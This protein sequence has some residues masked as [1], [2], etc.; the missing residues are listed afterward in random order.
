MKSLFKTF[1][2]AAGVAMSAEILPAQCIGL[3]GEWCARLDTAGTYTVR[4]P[5]TLDMTKA[6]IP[7]PLEP[8]MT[9]PQLLR[10]TRKTSYIGPCTYS[11]TVDIPRK[12]AGKPLRLTM[13]RVLWKS[14]VKVD[15]HEINGEN[16]SLNSPH[17][18]VLPPL[19][20]GPH[21]VEITV[22]NRQQ[23]D[24]SFSKLCHSYTDDTQTIWN[25]V[26]GR[27]TLCAIRQMEIGKPRI[28][29]DVRNGSVEVVLPVANRSGRERKSGVKLT[30]TDKSTGKVVARKNVRYAA[31][32]G[33]SELKEVLKIENPKL[34][35][36]FSPALYCLKAE[37]GE[38]KQTANFG[39]REVRSEGKSL[40]VNGKKVFLRG[41]LDCCVFPLTGVPPTDKA[42]WLKEMM[43]LKDWGFNHIRFHSWCPPEAAFQI[44]D[45][46]GLYVQA[47][48]PVW[49]LNIGKD[50]AVTEFLRDEFRN[51][52]ENYGNHPSWIMST[53][54]N[55]LQ[56]DFTVLNGLVRHMRETDPRHL[57]AATSFTFEKG[58]GGHAEP[59]DQFLIT[60]WTDDG[61][62]RGQGV[63]DSE[64]PSFDRN[65][66][67]SMGCVSVP[68]VSH[69]IGQYAVYP[70]L[71]EIDKYT[72]VL[73][74]LNFKAIRN[75][76]QA[77]GLSDKAGEYLKRTGAFARILYKEEIERALKTSG[78]SGYQLLGI[79]DFPGQG[80][81]LVGLLNVFWDAKADLSGEDFRRFNAPVV[82]L[83][84]FPKA[85]YSADEDFTTKILVSNFGDSALDESRI[86]WSLKGENGALASG[87]VSAASV[88]QGAVN[89]IDSLKISLAGITAP[90]KLTFS[91]NIDGTDYENEWN[92]WVYPSVPDT[93]SNR[94]TVTSDIAEARA[95]L[96]KGGKVLYLP[97]TDKVTGIESK[98]LPV[99]WSPVHFPKQAGGMGIIA[100]AA[101]PSLKG[102]PND[103]HSDWQWWRPVK[104][105]RVMLLDSITDSNTGAHIEPIV[106]VVDN[107]YR[108]RRLG[109]VFE[110]KCGNGKIFVSSIDLNADGP[111]MKSLRH[112]ILRYIDSEDFNPQAE[113]R[114]TDIERLT[115]SD[116][117]NQKTNATSIYQ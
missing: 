64:P 73:D 22:D 1:V 49:S 40:F 27:F 90:S 92:I 71:G 29:P 4:L 50:P 96:D 70:D 65:Y 81:A 87:T 89:G 66:D 57:Y 52:S 112:G 76:L 37:A 72:G 25:G 108:N 44:A 17:T 74:P 47:E 109:Y 83:A 84:A 23:R 41:T 8:A 116:N 12:M 115:D 20:A 56:K 11:R 15:G 82:P 14:T 69:E 80:T 102:F 36:E 26:L 78:F 39:M 32:A 43:T 77:K 67:K 114:F 63:F 54:G 98:F 94:V 3:D 13:E 34:W 35:N 110:A 18:F 88:P 91:L 33:E 117:V 61:W 28:Y 42:G 10:L 9:K 7:C 5:G 68:L 19:T 113:V 105:A 104:N 86:T 85:V 111:E 93:V 106:G 107:F 59:H 97:E 16:I 55:E 31:P 103:G 46:L 62:V 48:L 2:L 60:Q 95:A 21:L 58:H 75:D 24:I 38:S 6:G 79:Q 53:C 100:D 99:F 101:H 30:V 51:M 45:S